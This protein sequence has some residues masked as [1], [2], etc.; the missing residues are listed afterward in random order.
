MLTTQL[1]GRRQN[2]YPHEPNVFFGMVIVPFISR[3][4]REQTGYP[5]S[6]RFSTVRPVQVDLVL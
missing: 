4:A 6:Q 5:A 2:P 3:F 1:S